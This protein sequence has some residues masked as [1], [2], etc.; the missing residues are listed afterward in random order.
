MLKLAVLG[1]SSP[2]FTDN[3]I[4]K[5]EAKVV[6]DNHAVSEGKVLTPME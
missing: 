3:F 4:V 5:N 1:P 6:V 2:E